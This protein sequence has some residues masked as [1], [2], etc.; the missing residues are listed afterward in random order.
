LTDHPSSKRGLIVSILVI[1]LVAAV[2]ILLNL[3]G[4]PG[5]SASNSSSQEDAAAAEVATYAV[6]S[7]FNVDYREGIEAWLERICEVSSKAGCDLLASGSDAMWE[8]Y[9]KEKTVVG[10][11]RYGMEKLSDRGEEQVWKMEITLS[12]PF[13][14]SNKTEDSAYVLLVKQGKTWKFDRFLLPGEI[15]ALHSSKI[16]STPEKVEGA[17]K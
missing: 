3:E 15:H 9:L 11:A 13:P 14:G 5:L 10:A 2:L 4:F 7:I 6:E 8:K 1:F 12:A 16:S 17:T